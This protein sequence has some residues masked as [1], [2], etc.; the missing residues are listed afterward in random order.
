MT[1]GGKWGM[2]AGLCFL[3]YMLWTECVSP[4]P[5]PQ[6]P[7]LNPN[8]QCDGGGGAFGWWLSH[9]GRPLMNG[10]SALTKEAPRKLSHLFCHMRTQ[11]KGLS[12]NQEVGSQQIP[13]L[14]APSSL[15]FPAPRAVRNKFILFM[16]YPVSGILLQQ[17]EWTNTI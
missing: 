17:P 8:T 10:I 14:P 4:P 3:S 13:N 7:M 12:R 2:Q 16:N 1:R 15:N 11:W 9:E 5:T 6:I